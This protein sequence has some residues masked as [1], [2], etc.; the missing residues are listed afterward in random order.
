MR[1]RRTLVALAGLAVVFAALAFGVHVARQPAGP[2]VPVEIQRRAL[3]DLGEYNP[4]NVKVVRASATARGYSFL[5]TGSFTVHGPP[6]VPGAGG[7]SSPF[8]RG[9]IT[10]DTNGDELDVRFWQ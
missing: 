10:V 2:G 9:R 7:T 6:S 1:N 8:T 5:I 4:R 3:L